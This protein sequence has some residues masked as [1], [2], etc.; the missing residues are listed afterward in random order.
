MQSRLCHHAQN[1]LIT[2]KM[3]WREYFPI[4][5]EDDSYRKICLNLFGSR[6]KQLF[7]TVI[8]ELDDI[9]SNNIECLSSVTKISENSIPEPPEIFRVSIRTNLIE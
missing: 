3:R 9:Y 6:P 4:I 7:H 1:G 5:N 8:E 2:T